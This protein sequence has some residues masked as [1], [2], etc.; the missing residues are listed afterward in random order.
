MSDYNYDDYD[1]EEEIHYV[2]EEIR[3]KFNEAERRV[4]AFTGCVSGAL[5]ASPVLFLLL[6]KDNFKL[7]FSIYLSVVVAYSF[8]FR[9]IHKMLFGQM[10]ENDYQ[11]GNRTFEAFER[12][13]LEKMYRKRQIDDDIYDYYLDEFYREQREE[14]EWEY[15]RYVRRTRKFTIIFTL[16]ALVPTL[17][18]AISKVKGMM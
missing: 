17:V 9:I 18:Y 7:G 10:L 6:L 13:L 1:I 5:S 12:K 3:Y 4:Y 2:N 11:W 15:R 16:L 8:I 14:Y